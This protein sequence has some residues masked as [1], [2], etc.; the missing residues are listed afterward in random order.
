MDCE[1]IGSKAGKNED[2]HIVKRIHTIITKG[3]AC[4]WLYKLPGFTS[5]TLLKVLVKVMSY[6]SFMQQLIYWTFTF[7]LTK[8]RMHLKYIYIYNL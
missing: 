1:L 7:L 6:H 5:H 2:L 3:N 4:L 8:L